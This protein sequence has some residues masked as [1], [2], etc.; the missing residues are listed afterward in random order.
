MPIGEQPPLIYPVKFNKSFICVI[1]T[2]LL[3]ETEAAFLNPIPY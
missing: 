2:F 3:P 1:S